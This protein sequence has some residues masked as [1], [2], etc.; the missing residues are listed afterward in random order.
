MQKIVL[1]GGCFWCTEA[2][3]LRVKGVQKVTSGYMGGSAD[4]ANYQ[5]VCGGDTGHVEVILVEFDDN[6]VDLDTIFAIFFTI[7]DPTTVDRQGND[8]GS[9][10]RSAI[11]YTNENQK[12]IAETMITSLKNQGINIVTQLKPSDIFYPAEDYHQDFF[13]KNP[14]QG[15]CNFAIPPKLIKLRQNFAEVWQD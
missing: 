12:I 4:T 5:A 8:I 11:F 13:H 1:G 15:Y 10:Y 6:V 7:H 2:V 9:Q 14:T 3:F